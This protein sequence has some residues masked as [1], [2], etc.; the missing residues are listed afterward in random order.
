MVLRQPCPSGK[1]P[2][3]VSAISYST[4]LCTLLPLCV[5]PDI[6]FTK[7]LDVTDGEENQKERQTTPSLLSVSVTVAKF[8][9]NFND[10]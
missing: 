4:G 2:L 5:M 1:L 10:Y 7:W 6:G 3:H 9:S 8:N